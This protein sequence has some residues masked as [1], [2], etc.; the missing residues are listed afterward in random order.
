MY[1]LKYLFP[2]EKLKLEQHFETTVQVAQIFLTLTSKKTMSFFFGM[3]CCDKRSES[4]TMDS[5][6]DYKTLLNKNLFLKF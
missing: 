4:K 3:L 1:L 6:N 2:V 5:N